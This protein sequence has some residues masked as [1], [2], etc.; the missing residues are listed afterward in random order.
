MIEDLAAAQ[1]RIVDLERKLLRR[2]QKQKV[3]ADRI[4]RMTQEMTKLRLELAR[5]KQDAWQWR[6]N[7][8]SG[9]ALREFKEQNG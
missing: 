3:L 2:R 7:F 8:Y 6:E 5:A 4:S 1:S 9:K